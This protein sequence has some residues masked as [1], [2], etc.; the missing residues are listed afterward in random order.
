[1]SE[2]RKA[3]PKRREGA[4]TKRGL[5][6]LEGPS[7]HLH[8]TRCSPFVRIL[9]ARLSGSVFFTGILYT[10]TKSSLQNRS[11]RAALLIAAAVE[12]ADTNSVSSNGDL[13]NEW[14]HVRAQP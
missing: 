3:V 14:H 1:M 9:Q 5:G 7:L 2:V 6:A 8:S 12:I 10:S 4:E 11:S 13:L